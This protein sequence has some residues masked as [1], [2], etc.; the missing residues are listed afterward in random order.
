MADAD[1][2]QHDEIVLIETN[3]DNATGELLG[4]LMDRL[5]DAGALDVNYLPMQMK[6]NRP[7]TLVRV[8]ARSEDA[9]RLAALLV[10]ETPTLGVRMTPMR[11]LIAE[12]RSERTI[13][14]L[15]EVTVKLKLLGGKVVGASPEY[16]DCARIAAATGLDLG[17]VMARLDAWLR[18]SFN[19]TESASTS[20][21]A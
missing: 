12:R 20:E 21:Q 8:L 1:D 16:D 14:P 4:W 2:L 7:A 3:L 9:D 17:E 6:K 11:R 13:S 18:T 5:F 19:L 15:G 10:R